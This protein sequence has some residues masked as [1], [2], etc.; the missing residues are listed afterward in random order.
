MSMGLSDLF[1]LVNVTFINE[2]PHDVLLM[3][4][5]EGF[6]DYLRTVHPGE[7]KYWTVRD[8][9]FPLVWCY[10]HIDDKQQ[11]V[12]WGYLPKYRCDRHCKWLMRDDGLY[13]VTQYEYQY[14][15]L[16]TKGEFM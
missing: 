10:L 7:V 16:N 15:Y 14:I 4:N 8:I 1:P 6:Q 11:G 12:F 2:T 9:A 13:L 5:K 3:C